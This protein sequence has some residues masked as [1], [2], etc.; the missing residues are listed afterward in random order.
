MQLSGMLVFN[1]LGG[2]KPGHRCSPVRDLG[3]P[4]ITISHVEHSNPFFSPSYRRRPTLLENVVLNEPS[5]LI[6]RMGGHVLPYYID[7]PLKEGY[8]KYY[9]KML[10]GV[11]THIVF[12]GLTPLLVKLCDK[13]RCRTL[14]EICVM[15]VGS[16]AVRLISL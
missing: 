4:V 3:L 15:V 14:P 8:P 6:R 13:I 16:A 10:T 1:S 12:F 2:P 9:P 5:N 11:H 7:W